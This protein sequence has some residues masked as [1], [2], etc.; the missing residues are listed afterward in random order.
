MDNSMD[1]SKESKILLLK[2]ARKTIEEKLFGRSEINIDENVNKELDTISGVFVTIHKKGMLRGC[3]GNIFGYLPL[4]E[5]VKRLAIE[6]AFK[7]PRF[8]PL[9]KEEYKD[10]DIEI[11]ILS[12]PED[13]D[14]EDIKPGMGVVLSLGLRSATY[15]PQV[16]EQ[17][18]DKEEFL[19]SLCLKTGLDRNCFKRH[20]VRFKT[21]KGIVFSE[22]E[23]GLL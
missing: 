18:P 11:T 19:S 16:W 23:M 3:I 4:K 1:I 2:I 13:T 9:N 7:D 22:K 14:I 5:A 12:E 10:I 6:S 8:L 17:L 15:L 21:Y 20:D